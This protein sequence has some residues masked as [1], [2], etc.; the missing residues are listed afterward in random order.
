MMNRLRTG[1]SALGLLA[2][3]FAPSAHALECGDLW[4]FLGKTCS[5]IGDTAQT[6]RSEILLS[7]YA[8]HD[9]STYTAEKLAVLNEKAWGLGYARTKDDADGD[10]HTVFVLGFLDSHKNVQWQA[11]YLWQ[12]YLGPKDYPQLGAGL[13]TMILQRP[14]IAGGVPIPAI[15]PMFSL[16]Y[17]GANI[18]GTYLP[19]LGHGLNN[20]NVAYVFGGYAF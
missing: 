11:G 3:L 9:R 2:A 20:G 14:D 6:G 18:Y 5:R 13:A 15:W 16:R 7:G 8:W 12:T 10:S 19:K 17:A 4:N 1:L